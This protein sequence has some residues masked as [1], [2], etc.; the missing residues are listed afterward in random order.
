MIE[1]DNQEIDETTYSGALLLVFNGSFYELCEEDPEYAM[2]LS[3][4]ITGHLMC[5]SDL[6]ELNKD[7]KNEIIELLIEIRDS[8]GRYTEIMYKWFTKEREQHYPTKHYIDENERNSK[9]DLCMLIK[10]Q[11]K[12]I[13]LMNH[14]LFLSYLNVAI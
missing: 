11:A 3:N 12:V 8:K 9:I 1:F 13:E 6:N 2:W 10:S 7:S 5:I 14:P 4:C